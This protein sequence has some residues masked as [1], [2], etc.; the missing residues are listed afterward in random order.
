MDTPKLKSMKLTKSDQKEGM[1]P[2]EISYPAY[3]WGL[4]LRLD[5]KACKKLP[6]LDG[7]EA[8]QEVML[9]AKAKVTVVSQRDTSAGKTRSVELQITDL[10]VAGDAQDEYDSGFNGKD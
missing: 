9:H 1:A 7:V 4:E 2:K 5:E 10:A 8:G 3:P 6:A